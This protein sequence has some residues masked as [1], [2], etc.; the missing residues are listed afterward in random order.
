VSSQTNLP[1]ARTNLAGFTA[2]GVIYLQG[3]SDGTAPTRDTYWTTPPANGAI[4]A[5]MH[6]DQ[7]DLGEGLQGASA[8]VSGPHG[9]LFGGAT[10][11]GPI[12]A[13][14]RAY[15]APQ[16]PFFQLGI[17]GATI[18]GLTLGG[19]VGQQIGYMNAAMVGT[20]DFILLIVI[21]WAFAHRETVRAF[22]EER[23]RRRS[24]KAGS[25]S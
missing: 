9:F 4:S 16:T 18:P 21:G 24:A 10:A 20:V 5:W 11:A 1:V 23:R 12:A 7:T 13:P 25:G 6:L 3:G 8:V 22:V 2:N 15:L 14:A 17:L 19:E